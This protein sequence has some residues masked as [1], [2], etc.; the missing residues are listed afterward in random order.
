MYLEISPRQSGKTTR[1]INAALSYVHDSKSSVAIVILR[2]G[3]IADNYRKQYSQTLRES[4]AKRLHF[5]STIPEM[6]K[7]INGPHMAGKRVVRFWDEFDSLPEDQLL[8]SKIDY[9]ATTP[10]HLRDAQDV[11]DHFIGIKRDKLLELVAMSEG[12]IINY[13]SF[14][15]DPFIFDET[16]LPTQKHGL[17]LYVRNEV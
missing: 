5:V 15:K 12:R 4:E 10:H 14:I 16:R 13:P 17:Y 11:L 8:I 6:G 9:Y 2:C 7:I 3:R 1:L